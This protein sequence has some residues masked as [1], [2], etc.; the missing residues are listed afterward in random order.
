MILYVVR[1]GQTEHN[2][3]GLGLGREDVP[4]T[5][6]GEAQAEA[7]GR[8]FA[9]LDV[10]RVYSSPLGR[11]AAV[12]RA[13][14]TPKGLPVVTTEDLVELDVGEAEGMTGQ[15]MREQFPDFF[16]QWLGPNPESVPMPGG[17]SLV[18]V[19]RRVDQF[20]AM[21]RESE[22]EAVAAVTHNFVVKVMLCRLLELPIASFR[23]FAIDLGSISTFMIR[24]ERVNVLSV[25]DTCHLISLES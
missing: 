7:V 2:R 10:A 23:D 14:A 6:L 19:G 21:L 8:R 25:N 5:A 9:S 20:L 13:I 16:L 22:D 24:S 11:A 1:H 3:G 4:L 18:D 17:E 12:A 15:E